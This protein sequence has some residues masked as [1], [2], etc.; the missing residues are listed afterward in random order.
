MP[1]Y[2]STDFSFYIEPIDHAIALYLLSALVIYVPAGLV[3]HLY[4]FK[5]LNVESGIT[6]NLILWSS[7]LTL[8]YLSGILFYI[9]L[10]GLYYKVK[11]YYLKGITS[12][13]N[14]KNL[15]LSIFSGFIIGLH[16]LERKQNK[17][18]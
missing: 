8:F 12:R 2:L 16:M 15:N 9:V 18:R 1:S 4:S 11:V 13:L 6:D 7:S 17:R 3:F 14:K 10:A 5:R